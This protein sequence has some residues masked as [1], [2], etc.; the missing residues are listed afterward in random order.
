PRHR[1]PDQFHHPDPGHGQ[2]GAVARPQVPAYP[3]PQPAGRGRAGGADQAPLRA[4]ADGDIPMTGI[5]VLGFPLID[6]VIIVVMYV[7]GAAM[8]I[9]L[10]R[11]LR[12]PTLPDRSEE[13]RV[14]KEGRCEGRT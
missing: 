14:G 9:G 8:L 12:G 13:R 4:P 3:R 10:W 7:V 1:R 2:R 5:H 11:L 6:T